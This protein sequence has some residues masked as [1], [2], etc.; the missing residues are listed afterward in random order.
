MKQLQNTPPIPQNLIAITLY[1]QSIELK[2][3]ASNGA[4]GY[5]VF[6]NEKHTY[7]TESL[8]QMVRNIYP[9][10]EY[11]FN[12]AAYDDIGNI[13]ELSSTVFSTASVCIEAPT[14]PQNL[15]ATVMGCKEV[16]LTWDTSQPQAVGTWV[17]G[18]D[19]FRNNIFLVSISYLTYTDYNV[20]QNTSNSYN[21]YAR[22]NQAIFSLS[23]DTVMITTPPCTDIIPP[24]IPTNFRIL[25]QVGCN[26]WNFDWDAS[27]DTGGSGLKGYR[28]YRNGKLYSETSHNGDPWMS[29]GL[30]YSWQVTAIDKAKNESDFSNSLLITPNCWIPNTREIK[31]AVV[32][33]TFPDRDINNIPF[34]TN[35]TNS[36]IFTANNSVNA[37]L[38]EVSYNRIWLTGMSY[39]WYVMPNPLSSYCM[40]DNNGLGWNC[41]MTMFDDAKTVAASNID[42]SQIQYTFYI[43]D[44]MGTAA[45]GSI[46]ESYFSAQNGFKFV[47]L[48]HEFGHS[49]RLLHAANLNCIENIAPP[50]LEDVFAGGCNVTR[51]GDNHDPMGNGTHH[52]S[53]YHKEIAGML[54]PE[55]VTTVNIDGD[56]LLY[57]LENPS[58][59]TQELRIPLPLNNYFYFLEYRTP[60][61]FDNDSNAIDGILVRLKVDNFQSTDADTYLLPIVINPSSPF[62]DVYRKIRVEAIEKYADHIKVRI[63]HYGVCPTP[64]VS[65]NLNTT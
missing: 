13:S 38:K 1:C 19:I 53:S 27:T 8:S 15:T 62:V 11:K 10:V 54:P 51:Y 16:K 35:Y 14:T 49:F 45:L 30:T 47:P 28:L 40:I 33:L 2:W 32:L 65:F 12:V 60:T 4:T 24:S 43:F 26:I 20:E 5:R 48:I 59:G 58:T 50:Y 36:M 25:N 34:D 29:P 39:G 44:G 31:T 21:I 52:Y 37:Y 23:S 61:G 55:N 6:V 18:Y 9:G 56:Y 41:N 57:A 22:S 46:N 42:M 3:S 7:S 63:T 17:Y 64:I